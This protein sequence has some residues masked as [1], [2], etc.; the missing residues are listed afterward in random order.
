MNAVTFAG[1]ESKSV[2]MLFYTGRL[3]REQEQSF[4]TV[5]YKCIPTM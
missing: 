5:I 1:N 4:S 2:I 3:D